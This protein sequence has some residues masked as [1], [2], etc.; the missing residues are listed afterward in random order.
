MEGGDPTEGAGGCSGDPAGR[1][2]PS[3]TTWIQRAGFQRCRTTFSFSMHLFVLSSVLLCAF[4]SFSSF[5][6]LCCRGW[7]VEGPCPIQNAESDGACFLY[8]SL[9]FCVHEDLGLSCFPLLIADAY[10]SVYCDASRSRKRMC[11][12]PKIDSY[13]PIKSEFR[14]DPYILCF[15]L[16]RVSCSFRFA[17]W[18]LVI[19]VF[20]QIAYSCCSL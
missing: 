5:R 19:C 4:V 9:S 6:F 16:F 2:P 7:R 20:R 13:S 1:P 12:F 17:V 8:A 3:N 15:Q 18:C 14:D 11:F 10:S